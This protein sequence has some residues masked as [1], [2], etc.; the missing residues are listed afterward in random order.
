MEAVEVNTYVFLTSAL[1]EGGW[2]DTL[3]NSIIPS[4]ALE[5]ATCTHWV[6]KL[7]GLHS[8]S[9]CGEEKVFPW[10]ESKCGI[11]VIQPVSCSLYLLSYLVC[12]VDLT[13]CSRGSSIR[14]LGVAQAYQY[15]VNGWWRYIEVK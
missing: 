14:M 3:A 12:H 11:P 5:G 13:S 1:G 2:L 10:R 15:G 4:P 8:L 7:R 6:R 9:G